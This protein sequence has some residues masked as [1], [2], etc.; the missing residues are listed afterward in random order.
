MNYQDKSKEELI[1]ELNDLKQENMSLKELLK[2]DITKHNSI[3]KDLLEIIDKNPISVQIL[4]MEG[5]SIHTNAAHTRLFGSTPPADY[6][7]FK[8][9]HL[10]KQGFGD[11]FERIKKGD[12]L[13]FPESYYNVHD[14]DPSF[15][16]NPLWVK[17]IGYA[18]H[19]QTGKPNKIV[20][21]HEDITIRKQTETHLL[22]SKKMIELVINSIPQFIFWKDCNSVFLGCNENFAHVAGLKNAS[23]IVGKTDYDMA[24]RKEEADFFI[25]ADKKVINTG[26]AQ[27]HIIESQLQADGKQAWLDTNK[28]PMYDNTGKIIGILGTFEDITERRQAEIKLRD[29]ELFLQGVLDNFPGIVFWKD[30]QLNYLGSNHANAIG[31]GFNNSTEM[32]GKSDFDMPWAKT[33]AEN[34]RSNDRI[35]LE[36][37]QAKL[38]IIEMIHQVNNQIKWL[39]TC[40]TPLRNYSGEIIGIL[41]VSN[42]ITELKQA[43]IILQEKNEEIEAQNEE[44]AIINEELNQIN[45][46]LINAKQKAEESEEKFRLMLKN[47]NDAF[48]LINELGEQYYISDAATRDTGFSIDELNG[49]IQNAI[50]PDDLNIVLEGWNR[51][52]N[53]KDET[54][55][56][57]YRHKHKYKEYIW[58]EAVAQNFFHNPAIKAAVVNVRDI[59]A[60][61]ENEK[62]LQTEKKKAEESDRLK[63]AFLQNMSHEI[64]TPMNAIMGFSSLLVQN[65]ENKEN[66][67]KFSKIINQRCSDLLD[68]INDILDISKIESG[69]LTVNN[70]DCNIVELFTELNLFF[71]ELKIRI[72]KQH[73]NLNFQI[74][75]KSIY[76]VILTDKVKLKQILIN[77]IGNALKFTENGSIECGC[78]LNDHQLVFYVSDTGIGIP[79]AKQEIIFERFS[80]LHNYSSRKVGGTGLGLSIVKGLVHLLGGNIWLE[81]EIEKGSKFNF[82][83][84]Y[85]TSDSSQ[86]EPE[87]IPQNHTYNFTNKTILIVEHDL[88]NTIYLK[89]I[90]IKTGLNIITAENAKDAIKIAVSH[91][92]DVIL[93]DIGLPDMNGYDVTKKIKQHKPNIKIIALTAYASED[94][95]RKAFYAGCADYIS[96]A[97]KRNALL[98][99]INKYLNIN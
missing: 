85:I 45:E 49:P 97:T 88:F 93:M 13:K 55:R 35:V 27:Y 48:V 86:S 68:I 92:I 60:I 39:D 42:D 99:L 59:T 71:C 26:I 56:I 98:T 65:H 2:N 75:K 87:I 61:K 43:E 4:N 5:Y 32:I 28:T 52:L 7:V 47:S 63:T 79:F 73:L 64:R 54:V 91:A 90:L 80:Q 72:D 89:E 69:Q 11:F 41:G 76:P 12:I 33:E 31:A 58:Y 6:C 78:K 94:E 14:I 74:E 95:K 81:S 24:W 17:A 29:N 70:E 40:K 53:N 38:H 37:G 96:K 46:E 23:E 82:S 62:E 36:S 20:L 34:Y 44:Y 18:I 51:V 1:K 3:N 8:D 10:L 21:T 66:L 77:L 19:D 22:E 25:E 67:E 16:D 50:Y 83:I 9:L 84:P 15:P 30:L 57:Q